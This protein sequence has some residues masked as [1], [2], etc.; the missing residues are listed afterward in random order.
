MTDR[1]PIV[2]AGLAAATLATA[3]AS[4]AIGYVPLP[5][6]DL[7]RGFLGAGDAA[8]LVQEIRVPRTLL[9]LAVGASLGLSGAALQ[10][11]LRNPLAE[12]GVIG[13][14]AAGGLGAVVALY[15]GLAATWP[16]AQ[17]IL[18][19][20]GA[21]LACLLVL[22]LAGRGASVLSL[23]LAGVAVSS[24]AVALTALA[25]NLAPNP[26]A[27][28]EMIFWL[29]G[30]VRDRSL[31]D[32]ARTVPFMAAGAAILLA[33]GRGID[34]LALGDETAI[35]L[36]VRLRRLRL[37]I[38]AGAA[39]AV[40]AA[41]SVAGTIGFV[42]LVVPHLLRPL[43]AHRPGR[44]LVPSALGGALLL[45]AADTLVRLVP[46]DAELHLG[47]VTALLG[48]PFFLALLASLDRR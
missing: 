25:L 33:S 4:L 23:V 40:G 26:Y 43:V 24:F 37:M 31:A 3:L 42:G 21:G 18:S 1:Y 27:L 46:T 35:S 16:P 34:A 8:P 36:G 20:A 7:A 14:S 22:G 15:F 5:L 44:L 9:A 19:M 38:V 29:L 6:S 48:A 41:A 10:G 11:L 13:I 17:P 39:L 28:S 32:V 30:S 47:V 45:T 2:V 12:P